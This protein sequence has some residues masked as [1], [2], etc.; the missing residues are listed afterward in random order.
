VNKRRLCL[1]SLG[2]ERE[3]ATWE[4]DQALRIGRLLDLELVLR[5]DSVSRQHAEVT[6][7]GEGWVVR[8]LGSTNGTFVNGVQ[9]GR[10]EQSL[11]EGDILQCGNLLFSVRLVTEPESVQLTV[12]EHDMRVEAALAQSWPDVPR[13]QEDLRQS[14][15]PRREQQRL[16]VLRIGRECQHAGSLD[17]FLE[18]VLWEAAEA[19]DARHGCVIL[20]DA[21]ADRLAVRAAFAWG[22]PLER[23]AWLQNGF[24][25]RALEEQ[26]SLLCQQAG[27][28]GE[29]GPAGATLR[30]LVCALLRS[31]RKA[32]GVLCLA[33]PSGCD[34]FD[35]DD[36]AV[37]DALAL[38]VSGGIDNLEQVLQKDHNQS[39]RLLNSL[40]QMVEL[41]RGRLCGQP[42]RVTDYALMLAE[43]LKL[44]APDC[45]QLRIGTPLLELGKIG[46]RDALLQSSTPLSPGE[47][48]EVREGTLKGA[49]LLESIPGMAPLLPIVRNQH[50]RWDGT[51]YPDGLAGEEIPRLARVV[52]V[53]DAFDAL[54]GEPADLRRLSP[55]EAL[56]EI[57]R[58]AGTRFDP[59]AVQALLRLRPRLRRMFRQRE[60]LTDTL[61]KAQIPP[62]RQALRPPPRH[63]EKTG[64]P[65]G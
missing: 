48:A 13:L 33:R 2:P 45:E 50:E 63:R 55:D 62:T 36:L 43:E 38:A 32:L 54:T 19:L 57:E 47:L 44:C 30:S 31:P 59:A 51:G 24:V 53:A 64:P 18:A 25:A 29:E 23:E 40:A 17:A 49:W 21:T 46:L 28:G 4:S 39:I 20:R 35:R 9:V 6:R 52:A 65:A 37:A 12:S 5:D 7:K 56:H 41:R 34:P 58:G 16:A 10:A 60:Q 11:S 1:R 27:A 14:P 15:Q 3:G 8:D 26:R 42:R 22:N 61:S